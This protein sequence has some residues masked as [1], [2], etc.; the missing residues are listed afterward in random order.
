[1][2]RI[3]RTAALTAAALGLA[4]S[5]STAFA[6]GKATCTNKAGEGTNTTRDGAMFQAWEAVLQAYDWS[7]WGAMMGSNQKVGVAP[8]VQV[9]NLKSSC[10]PGGLGSVCTV[11]ATL[12]R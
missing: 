4:L 9:K 3:A 10:K 1:M 8:G 5:A 6:Q 12:C 7:V 11:Q 2:T